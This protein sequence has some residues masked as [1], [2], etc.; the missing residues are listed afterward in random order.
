VRH[1]FVLSENQMFSLGYE[2]D[3]RLTETPGT[4]P[5]T[6]GDFNDRTDHALF[7]VGSWRLCR[8]AI[9]QPSYRFQYTHFTATTRNDYLNSFG[10]TLY[11][12]LTQNVTLR[13][14]VS[15][16]K[17]YTDGFYANNYNKFDGGGGLNLAVRF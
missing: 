2:G 11:C 3:Y 1:D 7:A 14:Y 12:P 4:P 15:Y 5:G 13:T 8:H 17:F 10:L 16:D 9:L 6:G